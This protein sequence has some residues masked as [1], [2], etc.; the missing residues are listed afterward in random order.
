MSTFSLPACNISSSPPS[1]Q[2]K[3]KFFEDHLDKTKS[4]THISDSNANI[5]ADMP[6]NERKDSAVS[7]DYGQAGL[8]L[9]GN[10]GVVDRLGLSREALDDVSYN[11]VIPTLTDMFGGFNKN[12]R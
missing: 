7:D 1:H 4:D 8:S 9:F 10:P 6:I 3:P 2:I 12:D 5:P 11:D